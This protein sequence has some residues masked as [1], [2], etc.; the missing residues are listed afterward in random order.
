MPKFCFWRHQTCSHSKV[1]R[2]IAN[3]SFPWG[4]SELS[5]PKMQICRFHTSWL[6]LFKWERWSCTWGWQDLKRTVFRPGGREFCHRS[7]HISIALRPRLWWHRCRILNTQKNTCKVMKNSRIDSLEEEIEFF[8]S[9]LFYRW[10]RERSWIKPI[11]F[12]SGQ[13]D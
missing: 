3:Q 8:W 5:L 13:T 10:I 1:H 4:I 7:S 9:H 11:W 12:I 6:R 2:D